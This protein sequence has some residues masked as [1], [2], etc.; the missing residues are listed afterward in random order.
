MVVEKRGNKFC[1]VH[2][3]GA[4]AGKV[5]ACFDTKEEAMAQHRAIEAS[6]HAEKIE[7]NLTKLERGLRREKVPV[8]RKSGITYEYR[9]VG[10]REA[11]DTTRYTVPPGQEK[12]KKGDG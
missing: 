2:C 4:D 6:K 8:H 7:I 3:H 9:R 10:R 12:E 1:T 5:I 11:P